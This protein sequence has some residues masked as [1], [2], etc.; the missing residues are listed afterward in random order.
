MHLRRATYRYDSTITEVYNYFRDYDPAIGRYIQSDPIGLAGGISTYAYVEGNPL[1]NI[2]PTGEWAIVYPIVSAIVQVGGRIAIGAG[3]R[4]TAR[5]GIAAAAAALSQ[6]RSAEEECNI[7]KQFLPAPDGLPLVGNGPGVTGPA[8]SG[9]LLGIRAGG[10]V[11]ALVASDPVYPVAAGLSVSPSLA[12]LPPFSG[13]RG[14]DPVYCTCQS[15]LPPSLT[16]YPD[17]KNPGG[18]GFIGPGYQMSFGTF[19]GGI[20]STR[21]GWRQV[22][23]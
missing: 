2:D 15:S 12:T 1:S 7:F 10:D 22:P 19:Q 16:Y 5:T 13:G 6:T 17:P 9:R 23:R 4:S 8:I 20:V 11:P 3:A 21:N 18:K 14:K